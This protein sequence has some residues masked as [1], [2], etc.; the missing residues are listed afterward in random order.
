MQKVFPSHSAIRPTI[1]DPLPPA[2]RGRPSCSLPEGQPKPAR[3]ARSY[4]RQ[5]L[6]S[7]VMYAYICLS[8][9]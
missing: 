9:G 8:S 2:M 7:T 3:P 5:G 6:P 1:H 4:A